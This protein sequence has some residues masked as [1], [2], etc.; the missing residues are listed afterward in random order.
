VAYACAAIRRRSLEL[1]PRTGLFTVALVSSHDRSRL[2]YKVRYAVKHPQRVWPYVRR[3]ARDQLIALRTRGHVEYYR[4]IMESDTARDPDRAVGSL[5]RESWLT[6]GQRQFDYL[7]H[8]GLK[9]D[10]RMLEIGCGNLRAGRLFIAHLKPGNYHG[11]DI[12]PDIL[13]AALQTVA[14]LDLRRQRPYLTLVGDLRLEFLPDQA[15]DIVHAHSV[16]TH[17]P[18]E[19]IDECLAHVGR[20]MAPEGFFDFT[21]N[22]TMGTEHQ[23]LREDFYYRVETLIGL[24][25]SHGLHAELMEDWEPLRLHSKLRCTHG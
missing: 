8:H 4:A 6:A 14:R 16:F 23:V 15:F 1:S 17:S 13:L 18:L 20:T 3:S 5:S 10:T 12:S 22:R 9:P 24:A 7:M 19:V 11:V 21:F 25:A 2:S